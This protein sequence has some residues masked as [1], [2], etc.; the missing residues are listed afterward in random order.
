MAN[1]DLK[2]EDKRPGSASLQQWNE[3]GFPVVSNGFV[4]SSGTANV[5]GFNNPTTCTSMPFP[6]PC[7]EMSVTPQYC[8][9]DMPH[10]GVNLMTDVSHLNHTY[11]PKYVHEALHW[12]DN[13]PVLEFP[14][15]EWNTNEFHQYHTL[16]HPVAPGNVISAATRVNSLQNPC[17]SNRFVS[18]NGDSASNLQMMMQ[19]GEVSGTNIGRSQIIRNF[20][21]SR[22]R[23]PALYPTADGEEMGMNNNIGI[24]AGQSHYPKE[25]DGNFLTLGIGGDTEAISKSISFGRN[26]GSN[27]E[28]IVLPQENIYHGQILNRSSLNPSLNVAD[29]YPVFQNNDSGYCMLPH[30]VHDFSFPIDDQNVQYGVSLESFC[31]PSHI[32]QTPQGDQHHY[33]STPSN[34][35][36]GPG[37]GENRI[38]E[39]ADLG[40]NSGFQGYS[41]MPSVPLEG[42]QVGLPDNQEIGLSLT[43]SL[44]PKSS[45][46]PVYDQSQYHCLDTGRTSSSE[47]SLIFPPIGVIGSNSVSNQS[48]GYCRLFFLSIYCY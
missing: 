24:T 11:N 43:S 33:Y 21:N 40:P 23:M 12:K 30:N 5:A 20:Q 6:P 41:T 34:R 7:G 48:G 17:M 22:D 46:Q 4:N 2:H 47:S 38:L 9:N 44:I 29:G 10:S 37:Y 35:N 18:N 28:R 31:N 15:H 45:T 27:N 16:E 3:L 26:I 32:I 42:N 39:F 1:D 25:L 36:L 13:E 8:T 19:N 14:C